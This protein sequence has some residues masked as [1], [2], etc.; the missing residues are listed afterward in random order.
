VR[1]N[2]KGNKEKVNS[3]DPIIRKNTNNF[4]LLLNTL[5]TKKKI[6][7]KNITT[8]SFFVIA[9][10]ISTTNDEMYQV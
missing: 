6:Q 2:E 1:R 3:I 5:Q 9:T 4:S 7:I 8:I 10:A